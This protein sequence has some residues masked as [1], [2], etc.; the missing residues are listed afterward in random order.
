MSALSASPALHL[1]VK[2]CRCR[3]GTD[4]RRRKSLLP[5]HAATILHVPL[6]AGQHQLLIGRLAT[7]QAATVDDL[8]DALAQFKLDDDNLFTVIG[9]SGAAPPPPPA[10]RKGALRSQVSTCREIAF[11]YTLA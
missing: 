3:C 1:P 5:S 10:A 11:P 7:A 4:R 6:E 9:T 8:Y 2:Q